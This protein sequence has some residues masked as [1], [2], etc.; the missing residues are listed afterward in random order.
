MEFNKYFSFL[1]DTFP[2]YT[3]VKYALLQILRVK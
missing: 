3:K 2:S 1:E